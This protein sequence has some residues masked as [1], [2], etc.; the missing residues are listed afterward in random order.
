ML[1]TNARERSPLS[2]IS[3]LT[4]HS[5]TTQSWLNRTNTFKNNQSASKD[6]K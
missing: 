1:F 5:S 2:A 6:F 3:Q 4:H